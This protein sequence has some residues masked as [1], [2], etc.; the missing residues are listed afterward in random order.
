LDDLISK[1]ESL[2]DVGFVEECETNH[3]EIVMFWRN[4]EGETRAVRRRHS[5]RVATAAPRLKPPAKC[6]AAL[7]MAAAI[8]TT[9]SC[10]KAAGGMR[11]LLKG[12]PHKRRTTRREG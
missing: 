9:G 2:A 3:Y 11:P 5:R 8:T 10:R 4:A 7:D 1:S 6:E 12:G